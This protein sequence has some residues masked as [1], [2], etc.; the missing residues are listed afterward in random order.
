MIGNSSPEL[1]SIVDAVERYCGTFVLT[2]LAGAATSDLLDVA[3]VDCWERIEGVLDR[4]L[5]PHEK[6]QF[7][8]WLAIKQLAYCRL[9]YAMGGDGSSVMAGWMQ[10]YTHLILHLPTV[11]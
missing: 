8:L 3:A 9:E 10:V 7:P 2:S 11:D 5:P 1:L 4:S 6:M